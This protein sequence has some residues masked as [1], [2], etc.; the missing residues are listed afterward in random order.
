MNV[1]LAKGGKGGSA[2][3]TKNTVWWMWAYLRLVQ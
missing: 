3:A 1:L 2:L